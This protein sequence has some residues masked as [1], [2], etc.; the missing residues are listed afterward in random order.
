M[1]CDTL[2]VKVNI[3]NIRAGHDIPTGSPL[4]HMILIVSAY[5]DNEVPLELLTGSLLPD[6]T[7][8]GDPGRVLSF[9]IGLV[10]V[11]QKQDI[12]PGFQ[13]KSM[14]RSW[15]KSGASS[16]RLDLTGIKL[17]CFQTTGSLPGRQQTAHMFF[18]QKILNQF[19][20]R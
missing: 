5:D 19:R 16:P 6:W 1:L 14:P 20:S 8:Y 13:G 7:G 9:Q 11:I 15:K 17:A 3:Q 18:R 12:L 10:M 2:A 4:R